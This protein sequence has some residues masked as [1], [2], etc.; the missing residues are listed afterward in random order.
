MDE[1]FEVENGRVYVTTSTGWRVECLPYGDDLMR[2]GTALVLPDKPIPPT[3]IVGEG[4]EAIR[5]PYTAAAIE[6]ASD[7][8]KLAWDQYVEAM[9]D[10]TAI[11][12]A[13]RFQQSL[14]RSRVMV[15]KATKVA[16]MPDL[17]AWAQER[18]EFYGIPV[19][20]TDRDILFQFFTTDVAKTEDDIMRLMVGIMRATGVSEE[21]LDA[22]ES[23]FRNP[24]GR[25][26]GQDADADTEGTP[27]TT[28]AEA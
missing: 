22:F 8:D 13:V 15:H 23:N 21:V 26:E 4:E 2:A 6:G 11:E 10:Y 19:P 28:A 14:M 16:N 20:Q 1:L 3:Y 9:G 24:V 27:E 18:E 7:V 12:L 25:A 17:K 5:L